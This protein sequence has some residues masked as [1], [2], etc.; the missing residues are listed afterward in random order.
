[1][2]HAVFS[3]RNTKENT[4]EN[5]KE[6]NDDG[7]PEFLERIAYKFNAIDTDGSGEITLDEM[8]ASL[9]DGALMEQTF[10]SFS[11]KSA[12]A[13]LK[14]EEMDIN[15]DGKISLTEF[16]AGLAREFDKTE[17]EFLGSFTER[18]GLVMDLTKKSTTPCLEATFMA[19]DTDGSGDISL[20]E[21][22]ASMMGKGFSSF[23]GKVFSE[24]TFG[25]F[26]TKGAPAREADV[27]KCFEEMD[28]NKDGKISLTEFQ[29]GL[30]REFQKTEEE[31]LGSFTERGGL[32]M[33]L[34]KKS[35]T[36]E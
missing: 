21:M 13:D 7:L 6:N 4:Q 24:E 35:P 5:T 23:V 27:M 26:S 30:A 2:R 19:I 15:R 8:R 28:I 22:R 12:P 16:Q 9:M 3:L 14:F 17:E 29:A 31:F 11:S 25:S 20:D 1:V 10:G 34:M 32:V 18:G 33:D 36:T